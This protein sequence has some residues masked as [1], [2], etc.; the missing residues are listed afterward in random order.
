MPFRDPEKRNAYMRKWYAEHREQVIGRI[1]E[2]KHTIYA[3]TCAH[4]GGPTVGQ[5]K[6]N[7]PR[8]CRKS[9]CRRALWEEKQNG[10]ENTTSEE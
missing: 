4:C 7:A 1:A 2:R 9:D 10:R 5:S 8:Y 3:G 6:Q